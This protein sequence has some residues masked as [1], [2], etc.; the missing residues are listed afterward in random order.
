MVTNK[1]PLSYIS[2]VLRIITCL[3]FALLVLIPI[4]WMVFSSFR[5]NDQFITSE[6]SL[7]PHT[8]TMDNYHELFAKTPILRYSLNSLI[9]AGGRTVGNI[10]FCSMAGYAFGR[11]Q[12]KGKSVLFTLCL[13]TMMVPFQIIMVPTYLIIHGLN[14]LD[15]YAALI[16]P[17]LAG[18]FGVFLLRG[19]FLKLPKD[20]EEA[21][22][23]DGLNEF[24]IFA[25]IMMPLCTPVL[26]TL[27][28]FT[29]N[30]CWNDLMWPLLVTS[31]EKSRTL[32]IGII[33]YIGINSTNYG[34]AL[35]G[36]VFAVLPIFVLFMFGQKYFVNG[37]AT[38]GL[39]G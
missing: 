8:W 25:R 32:T 21:A 19:F 39:K 2:Q 18:M 22:R 29:L 17:G 10:F 27:T 1:N 16:V 6:P 3:F 24:G 33:S 5:P 20:L 28:I 13:A 36:A 23:V 31:T 4:L 30:G 38:T 12:F 34:P 9:Y 15:T 37:I 26:M 14:W 7:I 11:L 35:A